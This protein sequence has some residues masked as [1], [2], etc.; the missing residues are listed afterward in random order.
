MVLDLLLPRTDAG[1]AVQTAVVVVAGLVSLRLVWHRHD[2]RIF[3]LGAWVLT[4]SIVG[5]RA[6]H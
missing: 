1:V 2:W 3:V 6:V 5:V 4:L